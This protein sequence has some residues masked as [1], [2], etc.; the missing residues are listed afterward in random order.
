MEMLKDIN[1]KESA[2]RI[3]AN[4]ILWTALSMV[5]VYFI[6]FIGGIIFEKSEMVHEFPISLWL[7]L[8][9]SGLAPLGMTVFEV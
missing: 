4:R 3:W 6:V 8:F 2:K 7:T 1:G 9:G 5:W